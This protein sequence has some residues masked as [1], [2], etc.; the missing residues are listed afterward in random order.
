VTGPGGV[1]VVR[2]ACCRKRSVS[3][4]SQIST[5]PSRGG[6]DL[7]KRANMRQWKMAGLLG[8]DLL[9]I[10][11]RAH[12]GTHTYRCARTDTHTHTHTHT[13]TTFGYVLAS[14]S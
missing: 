7:C 6:M 5:L 3:D 12:V 4:G 10:H 14:H 11:I 1:S 2:G 13:H 9:R 8:H